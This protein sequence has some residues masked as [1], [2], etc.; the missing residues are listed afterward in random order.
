M[1]ERIKQK[2]KNKTVAIPLMLLL[3]VSLV[4][5]GVLLKTWNVQVQVDEV[6][7]VEN[8]DVVMNADPNTAN[9]HTVTWNNI[10]DGDVYG[11]LTW[12]EDANPNGVS[13]VVTFD[14]NPLTVMANTNSVTN[15]AIFSIAPDSSVGLITGHFVAERVNP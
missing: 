11:L 2:L 4:S 1:F 6:L 8:I 15:N 5:A 13:Y 9:Q 12:V 7:S 14:V 10:G 3:V